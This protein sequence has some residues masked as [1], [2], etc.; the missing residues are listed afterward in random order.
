M[1]HLAKLEQ[2]CQDVLISHQI[3]IL[4][5]AT[6]YALFTNHRY[7]DKACRC[8]SASLQGSQRGYGLALQ[9]F[10]NTPKT[11]SERKAELRHLV[12]SSVA[13]RRQ[14]CHKNYKTTP[15]IMNYGAC[16]TGRT[17][18]RFLDV[19]YMQLGNCELHDAVRQTLD[20]R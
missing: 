11:M 13:V 6:A 19:P 20:D 18:E 17:P 7:C 15:A 14:S 10:V 16:F 4:E 2:A 8:S 3:H 5:R 9:H 12:Y 1:V